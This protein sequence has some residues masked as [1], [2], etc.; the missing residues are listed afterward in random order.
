V[1]VKVAST[2]RLNLIIVSQ[3]LGGDRYEAR[4]KACHDI[5]GNVGD[6]AFRRSKGVGAEVGHVAKL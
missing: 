5:K 1:R 2:G 4:C 6:P 3:E